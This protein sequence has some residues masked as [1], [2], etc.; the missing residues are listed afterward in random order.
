[1]GCTKIQTQLMKSNTFLSRFYVIGFSPFRATIMFTHLVYGDWWGRGC[2][3]T[4][5]GT[6]SSPTYFFS[7]R[8]ETYAL[9]P[10][11]LSNIGFSS[12]EYHT[13]IASWKIFEGHFVL[14]MVW[15]SFAR[16]GLLKSCSTVYDKM[17][18]RIS[19][20]EYEY[21]LFVWGF[22]TDTQVVDSVY[23]VS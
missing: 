8:N 23:I 11:L 4:Y 6:R 21:R 14:N 20:Q 5:V 2:S 17:I 9:R 18:H 15:P 10:F 19:K 12:R 1:M 22:G 3:S 16:C 7:K 13:C